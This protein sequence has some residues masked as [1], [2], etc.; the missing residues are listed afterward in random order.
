MTRKS[1]TCLLALAAALWTP[2]AS[3]QT[4]GS[5]GTGGSTSTSPGSGA[6]S[7][8]GNIAIELKKV[9]SVDYPAAARTNPT[10]PIGKARCAEGTITVT[11]RNL[12]GGNSL[13]YLEA[14][15]ATGSSNCQQ[16]DRATRN[17][18]DADCTK[19]TIPDT[20]QVQVG[21]RA[22]YDVTL[23]LGP[24]CDSDGTRPIYFLQLESENSTANATSYG[25]LQ[26]KVDTTPPQPPTTTNAN[27]EASG[28]TVIPLTWKANTI[29][30]N[31]YYALVDWGATTTGEFDAGVTD[32]GLPDGANPGCPSGVLRKGKDFNPDS[33]PNGI[34]STRLE[35]G[36]KSSY[37]FDGMDFHGA[38]TV[39]AVVVAQDLAGNT[40]VMS[41]VVCLKV[42]KTTG[43]WKRYEDD[44]GTAGPG[45]ACSTPGARGARGKL[46]YG[47]PV[48]LVLGWAFA[49]T[50]TRRR[51]R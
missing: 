29:D 17:P 48:V 23:Q 4:A 19:L 28:Q 6:V 40:S 34:L 44:G 11:V 37:D 22:Y 1:G 8:T 49:R 31:Y 38:K 13:P 30:T 45:C 46:L 25:V 27:G 39:P 47:L 50:R 2:L 7:Q 41:D 15:L 33:I 16:G 9:G 21:N 20:N 32:G 36:L 14:W 5:G 42:T 35:G 3:A 12:Q 24:T 51:A 10:I 43:F 26:L 18:A